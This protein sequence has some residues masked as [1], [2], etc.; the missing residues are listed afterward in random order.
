MLMDTTTSTDSDLSS[1]VR[2]KQST[3]DKDW[4]VAQNC[5]LQAVA[6]CHRQQIPLWTEEQVQIEVL[7]QSYSNEQLYLIDYQGQAIGCV[8]ICFDSDPFWPDLDTHNSLFFHKFAIADSHYSR[9]LGQDVIKAIVALA[10][11]HHCQ[12]V[13]CDCHGD[14]PTLRRFYE[15]CGFNLVDRQERL[16]FD[17]ARYQ[18]WVN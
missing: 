1:R 5:L 4:Q 2:L 16:G 12:W 3:G 7:Q 14:R 13:R 18:I 9:G 8:F 17:A 10:K 6:R 15:N 11:L